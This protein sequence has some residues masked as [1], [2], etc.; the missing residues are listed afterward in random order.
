MAE[1]GDWF[2]HCPRIFSQCTESSCFIRFGVWRVAGNKGVREWR[3]SCER[4]GV[5]NVETKTIEVATPRSSL[6]PCILD[7]DPE[8]L[9][10]LSEMISEIGFESLLTDEPEEAVRLV[11]SGICSVILAD[12]HLPGV[13]ACELLDRLLRVDPGVHMTDHHQGIH[14]RIGP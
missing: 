10:V 6:T 9:S 4:G 7:D 5:G 12:V 1:M 3:N 2:V 13:H 8:Q 14:T 11:P